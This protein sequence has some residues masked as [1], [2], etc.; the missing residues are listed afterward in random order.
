MY[1][2]GMANNTVSFSGVVTI[3]NNNESS[4]IY[5]Y[6]YIYLSANVSTY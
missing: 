4:N 1:I 6:I 5:I 2:S 3:L